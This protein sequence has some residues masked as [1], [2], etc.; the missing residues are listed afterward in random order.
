MDVE[1]LSR[2]Q[3]AVAT[4]FHYI[5]VPL[6]L[7]LV[8]LIALME[9]QFARTG[10]EDY[11]RMAKFWGKLFLIN[12]T[13]G[14]VTGITLEFQFGTNWS[15]YSEYVGDIFGSLL[16]I[17]ATATFFLE[18]TF[19][20]VW[21]FGWKKMSPKAHAVCIWIVAIAS[22]MSAVWILIANAWMQHPVGYTIRNGR[23]ELTDFIA[24]ITQKFAIEE[25]L[26]TLFGAYILA[27]FFV[28]GVSAYHL[29]K[30]QNTTFF[31]KSFS[32][33]ITFAL[34]F[35]VAEMAEGHFH[36]ELIADLQPAKVAAMESHWDTQ[37]LAPLFLLSFPDE[38]NEKNKFSLFP[39]PGLLSFLSHRDVHA[40]VIGLKE[41]PKDERPPVLISFLSF[42]AMV[43]LGVLFF[44]SSLTGFI[45]RKRIEDFP[46]LLRIFVLMIPLPYIANEL[47]WVLAE[48]GRQPWIVYG[49]MK[50][51]DAYS[52]IH[53]GQ[54]VMSLIGFV[55]VYSLL[56]AIDIYLLYKNA[57]KGPDPVK[58]VA[59][60]G[61]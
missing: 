35:S 2:L 15:R 28:V 47:G 59:G 5:F 39:I 46:K 38:N 22:N 60:E 13:L 17:E 52:L 14:I 31:K 29:L 37:E 12:F 56:G 43:G 54:V 20:A 3:F 33:A 42:R 40:E 55:L 24:V 16:A 32:L 8:V 25:I 19:I 41:I 57:V 53:P 9:T 10:D 49:L 50:T 45:L 58:A 1:L 23:A 44:L 21:H 34:I 18:S 30:K 51:S 61:R 36:G 7:G 48:V 11:R 4:M 26:H 6:T 27:G